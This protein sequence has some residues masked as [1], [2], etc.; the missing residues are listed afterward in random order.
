[1]RNP[2]HPNSDFSVEPIDRPSMD[3]NTDEDE[4]RFDT[5][6]N[7]DSGKPPANGSESK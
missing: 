2:N 1:M 5:R 3:I 6:P 4:D 7:G